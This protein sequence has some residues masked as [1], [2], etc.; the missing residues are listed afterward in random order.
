LIPFAIPQTAAGDNAWI[1]YSTF[2]T[3]NLQ[4][5][6][7]SLVAD[8]L[9]RQKLSGTTLSSYIV[10]QLAVPPPGVFRNTAP[11]SDL[12]VGAFIGPRVLEL[13]YTSHRIKPYAADVV[14]EEPGAPF[15]WIPDRR[16]QI[17]AELDA[18][19]LHVYELNRDNAE[20]V[21][22]SFF[23]LRKYEERDFGEF[24][25]KRLVLIEYDA[26]SRAAETGIPYRSPLSPPPGDG[27]RHERASE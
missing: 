21:L 4:A 9:I 22:D 10:E 27:P 6:L 12:S 14:G 23:V 11:W 20:H 2:S 25:T 16:A 17:M 18:S 8:Y 3:A 24:R 5:V 1:I 19:M 13:I 26:M 15:R 7:S